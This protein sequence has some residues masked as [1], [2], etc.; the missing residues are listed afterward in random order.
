L[1]VTFIGSYN[2]SSLGFSTEQK[3]L[4]V[5]LIDIKARKIFEPFFFVEHNYYSKNGQNPRTVLIVENKDTF[6]TLQN[7]IKSEELDG[8]NL[9]IYGEGYAIVK[10]FEYIE[11]IRGSTSDRYYYFGDL[12]PEGIYIY[13]TLSKK[14]PQYEIKPAVALYNY[15]F[16]KA[17]PD[18]AQP[19][20]KTQKSPE[21]S[22]LPFL[23][24]FEPQTRE[25]I[26]K[27]MEERKYIPQ[28]VF[29]K[30]DLQELKA[31]GIF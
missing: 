22:L 19:L 16:H 9:L 26:T 18:K 5:S 6:W 17:G 1:Y 31:C 8:V 29:N 12:D 27:I 2:F 4:N 15:I 13:N 21:T 25:T 11:M 14:Y 30:T 28:E 24:Y 3:N 23:E 10:K 7:A 20:R